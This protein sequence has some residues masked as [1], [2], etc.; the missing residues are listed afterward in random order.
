[1]LHVAP[2]GT[3]VPVA[4]TGNGAVTPDRRM[5]GSP[6]KASRCSPPHSPSLAARSLHASQAS[7]PAPV[8][9]LLA[10]PVPPKPR[11][12]FRLT[13]A[14]PDE[15]TAVSLSSSASESSRTR[16]KGE[17]KT[18]TIPALTYFGSVQWS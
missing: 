7:V 16:I 9:E 1:M 5:A 3:G 17:G 11:E 13:Q 15:Q 6:R 8:H 18:K 2:Q 14:M 12:L 4:W 10:Q